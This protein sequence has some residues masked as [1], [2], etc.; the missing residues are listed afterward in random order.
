[1]MFKKIIKNLIEEKGWKLKKIVFPKG[2]VNEKP[3][4]D[5]ISAIFHSNGIF[6]IGAHRGGEAPIYDWFQKKTIW[7]EANPKIFNELKLNVMEFYDQKAFNCLITDNDYDTKK[8]NLS[9][10]DG[11]SSSIFNFGD[12][13][14]G[15]KSLWKNKNLKM[16]DTIELKSITIDT[17]VKNNNI[18]IKNY[19]HWV[20][21]IQGAELLALKGAKESL[22]KCNSILIEVSEG[23]IYEGGAQWKEVK[24]Y[25]KNNNFINL[26]EID[27]AH[28]SVLFKKII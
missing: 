24:E 3:D 15:K 23:N 7:L 28:S 1:M 21:D 13:S 17:F 11:A 22:K 26:T 14:I 6:H 12:L 16:I 18:D 9:S 8:F 25:L 20:I 10:N 19:N 4:L 27:K 2:Y 5:L